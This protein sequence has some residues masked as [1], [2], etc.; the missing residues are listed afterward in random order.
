LEGLTSGIICRFHKA[1]HIC[2][3][4]NQPPTQYGVGAFL[5]PSLTIEWFIRRDDRRF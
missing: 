1:L 4:Y 3:H 2:D 5:L